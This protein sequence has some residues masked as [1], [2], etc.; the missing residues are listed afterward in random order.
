MD[1]TKR[2]I[3][4]V[5]VLLVSSSLIVACKPSEG[6][7]D[8]FSA[9]D[10]STDPA[11][12]AIRLPTSTPAPTSTPMPTAT[13]TSTPTPSLT[14]T[15]TATPTPILTPTPTNPMVY[16]NLQLEFIPYG[17][18]A[19]LPQTPMSMTLVIESLAGDDEFRVPITDPNG[20][21]ALSL[22]AGTYE[23]VS[24]LIPLSVDGSDHVRL[25]VGAPTLAVS[26]SGCIYT[27]KLQLSYYKLPPLSLDAQ[28]D[29]VMKMAKETG[30]NFVFVLLDEGGYIPE[31]ASIDMPDA[32]EIPAE[33]ENCAVYLVEF[34]NP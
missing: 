13:S 20:N 1:I 7:S 32:S 11:A 9:Q 8:A 17:E 29:L 14:P 12:T 4:M 26:E 22:P 30:Q 19:Q 3:L 27:G 18:G 23:I 2:L 28:V 33:A 34:G 10:Q 5:V 15:S 25:P 16:G 6:E 24:V 21:Y 31:S